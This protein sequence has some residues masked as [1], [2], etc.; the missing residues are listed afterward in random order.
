L[1]QDASYTLVLE[2][3]SEINARL[4]ILDEANARLEAAAER[5]LELLEI[6]AVRQNQ[7]LALLQEQ[8]ATLPVESLGSPMQETSHQPTRNDSRS[9]SSSRAVDAQSNRIIDDGHEFTKE[10]HP[11][12]FRVVELLEQ[13]ERAR[14]LSVRQLAQKTGVSKS[15]CA[16]AKRHVLREKTVH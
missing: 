6:L 15:W 9:N 13:D 12:L 7:M 8:M 14:T 16:I 11:A 1:K 10:T 5:Q 2:S 3:I 4:R